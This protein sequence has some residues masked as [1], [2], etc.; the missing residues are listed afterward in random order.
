MWKRLAFFFG[1]ILGKP[2]LSALFLL[3]KK[4]ILNQEIVEEKIE[5]GKSVIVCLWHGRLLFPFYFLRKMEGYGLVGLHQDAEII[6]RIGT[7]MG[8]NPIRGSSTKGGVGAF[9]KMVDIL[10]SGRKMVFVTPDGPKGPKQRAKPGVMRAAMLTD[11]VIIPMSGQASRRWEIKNWDTFVVPKPF[12][13]VSLIFGKPMEVSKKDE[14][15]QKIKELEE[16]LNRI[17]D[18]ADDTV[19]DKT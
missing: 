13:S 17:Q 18:L 4:T 5:V 8:W 7:K 12:G 14:I 15:K 2:L 9:Q 16:E 6:S 11:A 1:I 19:I 3:N 10:S